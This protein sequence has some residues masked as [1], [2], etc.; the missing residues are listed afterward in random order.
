MLYNELGYIHDTAIETVSRWFAEAL[1]LPAA[2]RPR[3]FSHHLREAGLDLETL[4]ELV[5][6]IDSVEDLCLRELVFSNLQAVV[7]GEGIALRGSNAWE[8]EAFND[9]ALSFTEAAADLALRMA[10]PDNDSACI[11]LRLFASHGVPSSIKGLAEDQSATLHRAVDA[12]MG[13][14]DSGVLRRVFKR[15]L[16]PLLPSRRAKHAQTVSPALRSQWRPANRA[17]R[18][19]RVLH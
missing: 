5:K 17:P 12:A 3:Y 11:Q 19:T 14:H 8:S 2:S 18:D 13:T 1:Q 7:V 15:L 9:V 10:A 16:L 4:E 6:G